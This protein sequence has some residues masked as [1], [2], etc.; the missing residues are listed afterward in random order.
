MFMKPEVW[1][2]EMWVVEGHCG[3]EMFPC[4]YFSATD[5]IDHSSCDPHDV[6]VEKKAGWFVRL[7]AQGYTDCTDWQGPYDEEREALNEL[8]DSFD[9]CQD[10]FEPCEDCTCREVDHD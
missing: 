6:S 7:S 10:C 3:A 8:A 4:E 2:T 1:N 9:L 5:A